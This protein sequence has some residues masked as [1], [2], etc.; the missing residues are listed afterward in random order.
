MQQDNMRGKK[1]TSKQKL[2]KWCVGGETPP[3]NAYNHT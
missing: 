3:K 2:H 1:V